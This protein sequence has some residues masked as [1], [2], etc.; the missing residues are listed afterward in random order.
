M[1]ECQH[2]G[3]FDGS[4]YPELLLICDPVI[5]RGREAG[6][7]RD[8]VSFVEKHS[9]NVPSA[10]EFPPDHTTPPPAWTFCP[11]TQPA[12]GPAKKATKLVRQQVRCGK[13]GEHRVYRDLTLGQFVPERADKLLAR[14]LAAQIGCPSRH[15]QLGT[16]GGDG[17]DA[18]SVLNLAR[19]FAEREK[20]SLGVYAENIVEVLVRGVGDRLLDVDAGVGHHDGRFPKR[21]LGFC[22]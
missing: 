20:S 17:H 19:R 14:T 16:A 3:I 12:S 11:V 4:G 10:P 5:P 8:V 6:D 18:A 2:C 9:V 7:K 13:P 22:K 1:T 21:F 15:E